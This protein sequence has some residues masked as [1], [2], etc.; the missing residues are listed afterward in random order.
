[1]SQRQIGITR[2]LGR[3]SPTQLRIV[4]VHQPVAVTRPESVLLCNCAGLLGS[5]FTTTGPVPWLLT[6]IKPTFNPPAVLPVWTPVI[7]SYGDLPV[8]C[9]HGRNERA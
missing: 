5:L 6:L 8:S 9:N 7:Y 4:A 1:M 3:A 2:R